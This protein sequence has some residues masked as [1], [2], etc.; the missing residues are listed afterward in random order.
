MKLKILCLLSAFII[1]MS[2]NKDKFKI[3]YKEKNDGI[4]QHFYFGKTVTNF[5]GE[6][7]ILS[8]DSNYYMAYKISFKSDTSVNKLFNFLFKIDSTYIGNIDTSKF[9]FVDKEV[10]EV[11][12]SKRGRTHSDKFTLNDN[13]NINAIADKVNHGNKAPYVYPE[14]LNA[15][16]SHTYPYIV[17]YKNFE[18]RL[19]KSNYNVSFKFLDSDNY[20][21]YETHND[22][23]F[24]FSTNALNQIEDKFLIFNKSTKNVKKDIINKIDRIEVYFTFL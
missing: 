8:I 22:K 20:V 5:N 21:I 14:A 9:Y 16:Y 4:T 3:D 23:D 24:L 18:N 15:V 12:K 6:C 17:E 10:S 2:C 11:I 19:P 13:I 1:L 7:K